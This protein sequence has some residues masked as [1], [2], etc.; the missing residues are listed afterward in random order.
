[1]ELDLVYFYMMAITYFGNNIWGQIPTTMENLML[2]LFSSNL[3][4]TQVAK[5]DMFLVTL[6]SP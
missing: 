6:P 3:L 1:V 2:F 4:S 5:V